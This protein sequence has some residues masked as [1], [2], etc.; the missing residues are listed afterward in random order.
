MVASLQKLLTIGLHIFV[1]NRVVDHL[2]DTLAPIELHDF[3]LVDITLPE[4]HSIHN[5]DNSRDTST[6]DSL[7]IH[8]H[9]WIR[10][11]EQICFSNSLEEE[12]VKEVSIRL[13][14]PSVDNEALVDFQMERLIDCTI[15]SSIF[16]RIFNFDLPHRLSFGKESI[17]SLLNVFILEQLLISIYERT[18]VRRLLLLHL[19]SE[20]GWLHRNSV[21]DVHPVEWPW[22]LTDLNIELLVGFE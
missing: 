5:I 9:S 3:V 22:D 15:F 2:I 1:G 14:Q 20:L 12:L 19:H 16:V 13:V 10:S 11:H 6:L 4:I 8:V 17:M 21:F 7:N 18:N